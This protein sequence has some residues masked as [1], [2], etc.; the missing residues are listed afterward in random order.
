MKVIARIQT[1]FSE[2][3]GIPRQSNLIEE[4][5]GRIIFEPE[6]RNPDAVKGLEDFDYIWLLWQFEVPQ[7][8]NWSATVQPPRLGGN[9]HVGV[10]ATRSP[11]RPNSIGLSSV[12]LDSVEITD[13]GPVLN[14]SGIDLRNG[15]PIYDIKPYLAY[16]DS[17]PYAREGFAGA[18]KNYELQVEFPQELLEIFPNEKQNAIIEVLKQD[19]RPS[20]HEDPLRKYGVAFAGYDVRFTVDGNWLKVVEVEEYKK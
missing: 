10:F 18:V 17:H 20:Y 8:D 6:Y 15:T 9:T 13:N 14:V 7:K 11:F 4:L 1:D 19:P 12:R 5:K 2:K 3:F 16:T